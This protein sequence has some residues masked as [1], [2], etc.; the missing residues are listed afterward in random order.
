MTKEKVD[1][2]PVV[3]REAPGRVV[4]VVTS[5]SMAYAL[6]KAKSLR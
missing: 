2:V 4:G 3:V 5:K 1:L 6:E